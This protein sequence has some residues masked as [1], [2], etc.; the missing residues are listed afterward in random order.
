MAI[1]FFVLNEL[2]P[3]RYS[4]NIVLLAAGRLFEISEEILIMRAGFP[5]SLLNYFLAG[6]YHTRI[7]V[8]IGV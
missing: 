4:K 5:D 1:F 2:P 8:T 6:F 7:D 3:Q